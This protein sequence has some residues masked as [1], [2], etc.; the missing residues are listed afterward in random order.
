MALF[1]PQGKLCFY[2]CVVSKAALATQSTQLT[3]S[4]EW[5]PTVS[6]TGK[7]ALTL[8]EGGSFTTCIS[9]AF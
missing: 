1:R 4:T 2:R 5:N 6:N 3:D 8:T 9:I 7:R